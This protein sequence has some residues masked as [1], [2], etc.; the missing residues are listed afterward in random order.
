MLI[1]RFILGV[2]EASFFPG[3]LFLISKWYKHSELGSRTALLFCG[4]IISNAFGALIASAIL[5]NMQGVL[6]RAA[7]RWLFYIE[8]SLTVIVAVS[9]MFILPDFPETTKSGWLTE[10]EIRLAVRRMEED[11]DTS[12]DDAGYGRGQSAGFW[13][14]VMDPH[15]WILTIAM[16]AQIVSNGFTAWFPTIVATLGYDRT[17]TLLLCA[18]PYLLTALLAFFVSR[19]DVFHR[20]GAALLIH[21]VCRHSDKAGE[22]YHHI[23][24]PLWIGVVGFMIAMSTMNT[25]A[26]YFSLCV[27]PYLTANSD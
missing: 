14:A 24:I 26:R 12:V 27:L 3:A 18:P 17:V 22:R 21:V 15:V 11:A 23:T 4:N 25:A 6:G 9:A 8:G 10:E 19:Y 1:T 16:L 2:V 7:W 20:N 13:M 5:D